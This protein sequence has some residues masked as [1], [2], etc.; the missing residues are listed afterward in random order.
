MMDKIR[1][2]LEQDVHVAS[3]SLHQRPATRAYKYKAA[4]GRCHFG[5]Y[6][7]DWLD[8]RPHGLGRFN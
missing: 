4:D 8:G 7:G 1:R 5:Q 3:P 2:W 6:E